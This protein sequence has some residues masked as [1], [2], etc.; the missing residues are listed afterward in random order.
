M[1]PTDRPPEPA[2]PGTAAVNRPAVFHRLV[3]APSHRI[4][5]TFDRPQRATQAL[6]ELESA[7]RLVHDGDVWV[8]AQ[9]EGIRRLD[10]AG[11]HHGVRGAV[12]RLVQRC[13]SADARYLRTLDAAL[14]RGGVV[15]AVR[16]T[17]DDAGAVAAVLEAHGAHSIAR[18]AHWDY[19]PV[20][21]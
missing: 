15:V 9:D 1:D 10:A 6:E 12:V 11:T 16:V 17:G 5:A 2:A 4:F 8:F 19:V 13:M 14:R 21:A 20:A 7:G 18:V 3:G